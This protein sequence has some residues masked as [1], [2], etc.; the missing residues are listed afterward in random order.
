VRATGGQTVFPGSVHPSGEEINF[1]DANIGE[2]PVPTKTTRE[3]LDQAATNIGIA[4]VLRDY[5]TPGLRHQLSLA[6]AGVFVR[7]GWKEENVLKLVKAVAETTNDDDVDDRLSA[8]RTTFDNNRNGN[9]ITGWPT[10]HEVIGADA[11]KYIEKILGSG[12]DETVRPAANSNCQWTKANFASDHDSAMTF[13]TQCEGNLRFSTASNQW[14]HRKVEVFDPVADA[15]AQGLVGNFA[16]MA[17]EQLGKDAGGIKSRSKINAVLELARAPLAVDEDIIDRDRHLV[18]LKDGRIL[19]LISG[20]FVTGEQEVFVTKRLGAAYDPAAQCPR[21]LLFLD[22]IFAGDQ[23]K[24]D[25]VQ[26]A[27]GYSLCG[28]VSEQCLF[29]LTGSGANGKSTLINAIRKAFGDYSATTPMQ[30]LTVMPFSNG[31]TND[32]AAMEGKRFVS[33]SDGENRS[34]ACRS[35]NKKYDW[36]RQ[37]LLSCP[38]QRLPGI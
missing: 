29:I 36:W 25:Y 13:A 9:P 8:V 5:W 2:L 38:L 23:S 35:Q 4:S 15:I 3:V 20:E 32:L 22:T 26:R 33:A 10:L 17:F 28:E 6:L 27:V 30:T 34:A 24:I 21:W 19:D 31:Q 1:C 18:G 16:A 14:Y 7:Q 12:A 11:A 37:D